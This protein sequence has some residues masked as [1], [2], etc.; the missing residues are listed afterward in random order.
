MSPINRKEAVR[1]Y[2]QSRR[3]MGVFQVR[4]TVSGR[5]YVGSSSDL[6]SILNRHRAQLRL[7]AHPDRALQADWKS[8]GDAAFEFDVLDTI[9]P[10]DDPAYSPADDLRTLEE[11]WRTRLA[12]NGGELYNPRRSG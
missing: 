10:P 7:G 2:K 12:G 1:Q 6:P 4:N 3:P 9:D 11:L 8:L 5:V